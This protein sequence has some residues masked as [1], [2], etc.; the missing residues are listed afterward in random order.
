MILDAILGHLI[1]TIENKADNEY[2][3]VYTSSAAKVKKN[4]EEKDGRNEMI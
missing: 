4:K 3:V 2:V 1:D